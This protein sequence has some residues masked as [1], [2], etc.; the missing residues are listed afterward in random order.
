MNNL[1]MFS[2]GRYINFMTHAWPSHAAAIGFRLFCYPVR[3]RIKPYQQ[4]FFDTAEQSTLEHRGV[5]VKTY[6]WPGGPKK[7]LFLHGWQSHTFRWK[8]YVEAFQDSEFTMY[9]LDAP[10]HGLSSGA[11]LTVPLYSEIIEKF[12]QQI[13]GVDAIVSHSLGSFSTLY[14]LH[15]TPGLQ[16]DRLV[17][18]A[19]PGEAT[20]FFSFYQKALQ[21]SNRAVK[22]IK[23]YFEKAIGQP[24]EYFSAPK[25]A[26]AVPIPG[27]IIHDE[28]DEETSFEHSV[29]I[30]QAW[31]RSKLRLTTGLTHN[32]KSPEIVKMVSDFIRSESLAENQTEQW[33]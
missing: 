14:T 26:Q 17:I 16:V 30:H 3:G 8:N 11:F 12:I 21:L 10:G 27:L 7:I 33:R 9:A 25:F 20:E 19:S 18:L 31:K 4:K 15:R 29:A 13:G 5:D 32:L 23:S 22:N 1:L 28:K 24:V 6:R 2:L